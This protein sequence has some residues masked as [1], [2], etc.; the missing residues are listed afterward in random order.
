MFPGSLWQVLPGSG[1]KQDQR[2]EYMTQFEEWKMSVLACG[3]IDC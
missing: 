3:T 1:D 2:K